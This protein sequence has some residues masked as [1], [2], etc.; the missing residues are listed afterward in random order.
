MHVFVMYKL[1]YTSQDENP[2]VVKAEGRT[3]TK[4]RNLTVKD[5]TGSIKVALWQDKAESPI[6][7]GDNVQLSHM[8]VK[9]DAFLNDRIVQ[10]TSNSKIVVSLH[11]SYFDGSGG[12][13][14]LYF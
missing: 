4:V 2:R 10:S 3:P 13:M 7:M 12:T 9:H 11:N 1:A 6:K 5:A 8:T 14:S